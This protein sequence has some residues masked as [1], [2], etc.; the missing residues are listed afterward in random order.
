MSV[1][2]SPSEQA[3]GRRRYD[4]SRRQDQ[5]RRTRREIL[6]AASGLFSDRGYGATTMGD[7]AERAGVSTETVYA[8]VGPKPEVLKQVIDVAIAGDDL[9]VPLNEREVIHEIEAAPTARAKFVLFAALI[10]SILGRTTPL[11]LALEQGAGQDAELAMLLEI[12]TAGRLEGMTE[13]AA[14]LVETGTLRDG[15]TEDEARDVLWVASSPN[16]YRLFVIDRGWSPERYEA[17]L[18]DFMMAMLGKGRRR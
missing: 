12:A 6:E 10:R 18:A 1:K 15:V 13:A 11:W 7:I 8:A 5:A 3:P 2:G 4:S 9:P 17:W 16:L 14:N